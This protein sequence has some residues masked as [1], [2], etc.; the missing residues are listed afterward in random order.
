M[1]IN[2]E[3][4]SRRRNRLSRGV[5]IR[6]KFDE[7]PRDK[8]WSSSRERGEPTDRIVPKCSHG[9]VFTAVSFES[10]RSYAALTYL[11][12]LCGWWGTILGW[13]FFLSVSLLLFIFLLF[14]LFRISVCVRVGKTKCDTLMSPC[15]VRLEG[16]RDTDQ[17]A[18][19]AEARE[20]TL[21]YVRN[22]T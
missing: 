19:P 22:S 20:G 12:G 15:T 2:V 5:H 11:R 10:A 18:A 14:A 1:G 7:Q 4:T 6:S 8:H 16:G 21:C 9:V 13:D 3:R 17:P